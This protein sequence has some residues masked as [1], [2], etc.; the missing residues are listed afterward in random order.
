VHPAKMNRQTRRSHPLM[1]NLANDVEP[2][3]SFSLNAL[4]RIV[5]G[6]ASVAVRLVGQ[7]K[8]PLSGLLKVITVDTFDVL[9]MLIP[10][11][12]ASERLA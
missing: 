12:F 4:S 9:G 1:A 3:H 10:L 8:R 2:F 5:G 6:S 11:E 7:F